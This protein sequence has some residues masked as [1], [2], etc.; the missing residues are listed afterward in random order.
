MS[1]GLNVV[2]SEVHGMA[3]RGGTAVTEVKIGKA[4]SPLYREE[5]C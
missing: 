3:Q 4:N 2:M 5:C 1:Q